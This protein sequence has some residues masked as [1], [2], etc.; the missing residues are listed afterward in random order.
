[1]FLAPVICEEQADVPISVSWI[2]E[3]ADCM[4][5]MY[6]LPQKVCLIRYII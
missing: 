2:L 3:E 4:D 6:N 1:M 5:D